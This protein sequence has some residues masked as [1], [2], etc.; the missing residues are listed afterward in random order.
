[1]TSDPGASEQSRRHWWSP[2]PPPPSDPISARRAYAEVLLLFAASFGG[3]ILA[4]AESVAG[5]HLPNPGGSWALY[6]PAAVSVLGAAAITALA[7]LLL[8]ARRGITPRALGL[9]WPPAAAQGEQTPG[10]GSVVRVIGWAI[11]AI[12]GGG[13]INGALA[14]GHL[15]APPQPGFASFVYGAAAALNAGVVE[16]LVV[17]AFTISTLLQARRPLPEIV[18]VALLMRCSYHI[19]YGPGVLGIAVWASLFIWIYLRTRQLLPLIIVHFGWDVLGS[20]A[21]SFPH[22]PRSVTAVVGV[23]VVLGLLALYLAGPIT[24][25]VERSERSAARRAAELAA[26][27]AYQR[28]PPG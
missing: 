3:G 12:A 17:L 22:P 16:E 5:R 19:Y 28:P 9:G 13:A 21:P 15:A 6:G 8:S 11:L 24:W 23:L 7:V 25:L 10:A 4:A 14:T 2:L 26:S 18:I 20:I 27:G 1:M